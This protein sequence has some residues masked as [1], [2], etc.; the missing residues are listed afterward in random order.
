[1]WNPNATTF[2]NSDLVGTAPNE[3]FVDKN[4]TIYVTNRQTGRAMIWLGGISTQT[5]DIFIINTL[6]SLF[7]TA[8]GDI[9]GVGGYTNAGQVAKVTLNSSNSV[10][11]MYVCGWCYDLFIDADNNL[12]CSIES[13]HQIIARS[14]NS[15]S[16]AFTV[17]A[18]TGSPGSASD[19]FNKPN[20]IF[21]DT[22]F[23][24][25]VADCLN[26]RIQLFRSGQS[27]AITVAGNES[28]NIT[29]TLSRPNAVTLDENGY[30]FIVDHWNHRIV[31]SDANGFRCTVGC[32]GSNGPQSD[33]LYGPKTLSFDSYG[34]LFV[35]D[36][37]NNRIQKFFLMTNACSTYD[38][39]QLKNLE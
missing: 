16:N 25:Y 29:I 14:L 18:G 2:A 15:N 35:A 23:D 34:N 24:L 12:Y 31:G 3:V 33:Q 26:D 6:W 10:P 9:Y 20:G 32:S 5:R 21:V 38:K 36:D 27:H 17:I 37:G 7:V 39:N 13:H 1:M 19:S 30:L 11:V 22:N 8:A 28:S 4:N